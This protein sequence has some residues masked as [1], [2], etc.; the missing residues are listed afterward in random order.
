MLREGKNKVPVI[1]PSLS[2]KAKTV[3]LPK[4]SNRGGDSGSTCEDEL[5]PVPDYRET[6]HSALAA[7]FDQAAKSTGCYD[8]FNLFYQNFYQFVLI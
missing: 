3:P 1:W 7:A 4:S 8:S 5:S 6:F 2:D